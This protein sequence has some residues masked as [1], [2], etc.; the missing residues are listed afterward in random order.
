MKA[1]HE[2]GVLTCLNT[3][4]LAISGIDLRNE[5]EQAAPAAGLDENQIRQTQANGLEMAF[6]S[7][8]KKDEMREA[9][10]SI[11]SGY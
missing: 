4:N 5:Y 7:D 11:P 3:D 10:A 2:A 1:L 9:A 6:L 8:A